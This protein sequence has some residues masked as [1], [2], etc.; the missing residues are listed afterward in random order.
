ME[1]LF[2][3]FKLLGNRHVSYMPDELWTFFILCIAGALVLCPLIYFQRLPGAVVGIIALSGIFS[4][5]LFYAVSLGRA[6]SNADSPKS[7]QAGDFILAF[8]FLLLVF[9]FI[10][11][12]L[13]LL[14]NFIRAEKYN[15]TYLVGWFIAVGLIAAALFLRE[16]I[17]R[18]YKAIHFISMDMSITAH[19]LYPVYIEEL[20]F[21][22]S[23]KPEELIYGAIHGYGD[24]PVFYRRDDYYGLKPKERFASG[25][26]RV[27]TK[28]EVTRLP[29]PDIPFNTDTFR[30]SWYS[31]ADDRYYSDTFPFP[32]EKLDTDYRD[33]TGQKVIR[34]ITLH[35]FPGGNAFLL[36]Y[37]KSQMLNYIKIREVQIDEE[38]RRDFRRR[39]FDEVA[40]AG[41]EAEL[42]RALEEIDQTGVLDAITEQGRY[43][44]WMISHNLGEDAGSIKVKDFGHTAF[45]V[46]ENK[47]A[48]GPLPHLLQFFIEDYEFGVYLDERE[49]FQKINSELQDLD[50]LLTLSFEF[51]GNASD[52]KSVKLIGADRMIR[53]NHFETYRSDR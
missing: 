14:C 43:F 37:K 41:N 42:E 11:F 1:T 36:D 50:V 7:D 33:Y 5:L 34:P 35:L 12:G 6:F 32:L 49:L 52:I 29:S 15:Q 47:K 38:S 44:N 21:Y 28:Y 19:K 45:R 23:E 16:F 20:A 48:R 2:L 24:K 18:A 10:A 3:Y 22:N 30:L 13:N 9:S 17:P 46:G 25:L 4:F 39:F 51:D 40:F 31:V 27:T 53:L 8:V 26:S